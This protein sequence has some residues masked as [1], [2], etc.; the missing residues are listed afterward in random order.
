MSP[1]FCLEKKGGQNEVERKQTQNLPKL[2][3]AIPKKI[4]SPGPARKC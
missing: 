4:H 3:A 1:L 2:Q